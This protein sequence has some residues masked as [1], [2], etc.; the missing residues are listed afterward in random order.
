MQI[1]ISQMKY[2]ISLTQPLDKTSLKGSYSDVEGIVDVAQADKKYMT[3]VFQAD[4]EN[5]CSKK[6]SNGIV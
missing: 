6:F 1:I 5:S 4:W 2:Y 3:Y